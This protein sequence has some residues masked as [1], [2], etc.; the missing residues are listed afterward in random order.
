MKTLNK[1]TLANR[2]KSL[3]QLT[4]YMALVTEQI[5]IKVETN[6]N[7]LEDLESELNDVESQL[8]EK[9]LSK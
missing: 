5:E 2:E 4:R 8:R 1:V 7:T 9:R 6:I 3:E